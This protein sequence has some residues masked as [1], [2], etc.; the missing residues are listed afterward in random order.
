[1]SRFACFLLS[2]S[3]GSVSCGRYGLWL[4]M[5]LLGGEGATLERPLDN[6]GC[7]SAV[8]KWLNYYYYRLWARM[9][10]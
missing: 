3:D 1:M 6:L 10:W 5:V 7:S 9:M 8:I 2:E 4:W